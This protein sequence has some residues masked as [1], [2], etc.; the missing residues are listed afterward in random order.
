[1]RLGGSHREKTPVHRQGFGVSSAERCGGRF[2]FPSNS[3]CTLR[4]AINAAF[5]A[6]GDLEAAAR[7]EDG[8]PEDT[9]VD[10]Y[11]ALVSVPVIGRS[12][13]GDNEQRD[14][15]AQE[16]VES[17]DRVLAGFGQFDVDRLNE[18]EEQGQG[19]DGIN[20]PGMQTPVEIGDAHRRLCRLGCLG[21]S[22]HAQR[23]G[24]PSAAAPAS[25]IF[26]L[27]LQQQQALVEAALSV[28]PK[29]RKSKKQPA[30]KRK[31]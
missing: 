4:E 16:D 14:D 13:L 12:V 22:R 17:L 5:E 26:K 6:S 18:R 7:P 25:G 23:H 2:A 31:T 24:R 28:Q 21:P 10:M 30:K 11:A 20:G 9:F 15:P 3:D 1:M 8:P 27:H 29:A 19:G